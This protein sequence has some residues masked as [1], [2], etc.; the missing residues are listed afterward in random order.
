MKYIILTL[1]LV[2]S[3]CASYR[4]GPAD[5]GQALDSATT[6]VAIYGAGAAESNVLM[7]SVVSEPVGM[8]AL[9]LTKAALV[10]GG[11]SLPTTVCRPVTGL[12]FGTGVAAGLN[13]LVVIAGAATPGAAVVLPGAVLLWWLYDHFDWWKS[14]CSEE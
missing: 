7:A 2:C 1:A 10:V 11:K 13:N 14:D 12:L 4:V 5:M 3:G 9:A 8:V 6:A